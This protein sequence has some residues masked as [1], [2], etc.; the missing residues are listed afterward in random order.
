MAYPLCLL[1]TLLKISYELLFQQSGH[2]FSIDNLQIYKKA[3]N[4]SKS[5]ILFVKSFQWAIWLRCIFVKLIQS[6]LKK[7]K[8]KD[9]MQKNATSECGMS[10]LPA[11]SGISIN[12][13]W[14]VQDP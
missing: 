14:L 2:F 4:T 10:T 12:A 5:G 9:C 6:H 1:L 13:I 7:S 3:G 8:L 11:N